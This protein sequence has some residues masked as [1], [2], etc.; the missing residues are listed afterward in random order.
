M[1]ARCEYKYLL[2]KAAAKI[3][4][5]KISSKLEPDEYGKGAPYIISSIYYDT[6]EHKLY[7]Q[8]FDRV[9]IRY[10]LRL[11]VYGED[12]SSASTSFFE[13]KSKHHGLSTKRRLRLPLESNEMI[14]SGLQ[15]RYNSL[16]DEKLANDIIYLFGKDRLSEASVVSYERLAFCLNDAT[17]L[18]VTFDS[19]LRI[20]TEDFDLRNGSYGN[21]VMGDECVLE[22]KSCG[23]IPT[24]LKSLIREYNLINT[25]Y[26]KY[27]KTDF[28]SIS[29]EK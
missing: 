12:N 23:D 19:K 15:A 9:P 10:K 1:E 8:T 5:D 2:D 27:G 7:Q 26:S 3:L 6:P 24:W 21:A 18:R 22:V 28:S 20:R 16:E 4:C 25:S 11:R 29:E 14:R 17:R 13:I